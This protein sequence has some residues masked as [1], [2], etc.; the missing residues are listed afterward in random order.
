MGARFRLVVPFLFLSFLLLRPVALCADPGL[1][2]PT[3]VLDR[4]QG[5]MRQGI[6]E[7]YHGDYGAART[8]LVQAYAT[9]LTARREEEVRLH[10]DRVASVFPGLTSARS[11]LRSL[12]AAVGYEPIS[13]GV[14]LPISLSEIDEAI[15]IFRQALSEVRS[16]LVAAPAWIRLQ[17]LASYV[18]G[19]ADAARWG[20]SGTVAGRPILGDPSPYL[21]AD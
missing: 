6:D 8:K 16:A 2:I 10:V 11:R 12:Q 13:S 18:N 20:A 1:S 7:H 21:I 3:S 15:G 19:L 17:H 4:L 9:L 14:S 5:L